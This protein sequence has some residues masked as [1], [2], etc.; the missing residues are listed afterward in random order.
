[1][2]YRDTEKKIRNKSSSIGVIGLG[3]VGLPMASLFASRGFRVR[4]ADINQTIV[5]KISKGESPINE[6][7]MK[8]IVKEVVESGKLTATTNVE[9]VIAQSDIILIVVQTP[10][11]DSKKPELGAFIT[12]CEMVSRNLS[13]G[14]LI[15]SE[16]T[17]PPGTMKDIA[18]P[19]LEKSGLKPGEDFSLAYSPERAIP[20]RTLE[21]IQTNSRVVGGVNEESAELAKLLY[22]NITSGELIAADLG[23]AEMVKIIENTYRDVNIALANEIAMICEELGIDAVKAIEI[24]NE[25][26][27]VNIHMPGPG[28]GG[29]C[30]PKDPYFLIGKAEELGMELKLISSA[31]EIN[32]EMPRHL[33]GLIERSL[34]GINKEVKNSKISVLGIAYKGNTDDTRGTPSEEIIETLLKMECDVISHDPFVSND[35]GGRFSNKLEEAIDKSDCIVILTDHDIYKKLDLKKFSKLLNKP[36]VIIDSRRLLDP[37]A[38]EREGISYFG[39]GY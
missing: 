23:I 10:V 21:E 32:E 37:K 29:H 8:E 4:G 7:G 3:H 19:I 20:T 5:E 11:D 26:P 28:V 13:R 12:T 17:V 31:R 35:F 33:L 25:H 18:I 9:G 22:S 36:S 30:I 39:I 15:I 2:I 38:V 24:A 34:K 27:R 6:R 1:M 14:K 16:S